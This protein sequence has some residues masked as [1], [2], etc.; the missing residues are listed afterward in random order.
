MK[1]IKSKISLG[2]IFLFS[3]ILLLSILGIIFINQLAL[4]SKGTIVENYNSV[5]YMLIMI[6]SLDDM[7]SYQI[8][9]L[10]GEKTKIREEDYTLSKKICENNLQLETN[11]ITESGEGELV[12]ELHS[13]YRDYLSIF[14][15]LKSSSTVSAEDLDLFREKFSAVRNKV[16]SIYRINMDAIIKKN[17]D[18]QSTADDVIIYMTIVAAISILI[19]LSFILSF[20]SRIIGPIKELTAKIKAISERKYDQKLAVSSDDELGEL[21]SAFNVMAERL[22]SYEAKHIDQLLF[23]QKRLE[24]VVHNFEDGILITDENRKVVLVNNMILQITGL[25]E[26]DILHKYLPDIAANNDLI[27]EVYANVQQKTSDSDAEFKPMRILQNGKEY[28]F[29]L[30]TEEIITYAESEKKET[31]IGNLILLKNVTR[32]QERDRA[33]TNLLATAS[34]EFKTPLSAI[35]L[36]LKL[37][38]DK[39]IGELNAEQKEVIRGLRQQSGRLSRV[40]NELLDYSQI[41]SGNIRLKFNPVKPDLIVDIG[42]STLMMQVAEKDINIQTEIEENLPEI[43]VDLEKLAFVFINILNNAL[44]YSRKGGVIKI[45]VSRAVDEVKFS[46]KDDGPG[47]SKEDQDK[48]FK[49]YTQVGNKTKEGWGLGLAISKEFIQAQDGKIWVESEMGKG[50]RFTFSL[51]VF[52]R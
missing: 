43:K 39:R 8:T 31:F 27:K 51:P 3:V 15:K 47:I 13:A 17:G 12:N 38:E 1:S 44:R 25:N 50:S 35:N 52:V 29:N 9:A 20:P 36:S 30:E 45:N 40:I 34:H 10:R 41:E 42:L 5:D 22:K 2:V 33:K 48:L 14:E 26:A 4:K 49:R 6:N 19:G 7:N 21:A 32:F 37:L 18:L 28:Y 23:E 11:N 46:I 16:N 24:T